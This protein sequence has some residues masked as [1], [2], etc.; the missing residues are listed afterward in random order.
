MGDYAVPREEVV[1]C[2]LTR[3]TI[4]K[5]EAVQLTPVVWVKASNFEAFVSVQTKAVIAR[6]L[7]EIQP[8]CMEVWEAVNKSAETDTPA[9][10]A[11]D[12]A[13][14][15]EILAASF[16]ASGFTTGSALLRAV[17]NGF[18]V[19]GAVGRPLR[20]EAER[21][22]VR[23]YQALA[24]QALEAAVLSGQITSSN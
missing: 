8:R 16:G 10:S 13:L 19:S 4:Y 23:A 1:D 17:E 11:V 15:L 9:A 2:I 18:G 5:I 6:Y 7:P 12:S 14:K 24:L 22:A 3:E 21:F 20:S